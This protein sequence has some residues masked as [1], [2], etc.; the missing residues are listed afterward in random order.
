MKRS[1]FARKVYERAPAAPLRRVERSGVIARISA[2]V[3]AI[4]KTEAKRN[5][6]LLDMARGKPCLLRI[7]DVC[8]FD[9][10]TTVACHSNL[11]LHGKAGARKADDC[12]SVWGCSA[13]H[14]WLDHGRA[15]QVNK[16]LAFMMAHLAQVC[17]W[18]AIASSA[19]ADP[20]D[21]AAAQWALDHLNATPLGKET[22]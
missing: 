6:H 10:E 3:S 9:H 2:T 1:G 12:Y 15:D 7:S 20:K 8:N 19:A 21:R 14:E 16:Q 5:P 18:R 17:E 4:P 11:G 22:L 13:C